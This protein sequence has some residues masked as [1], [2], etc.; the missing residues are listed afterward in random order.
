MKQSKKRLPRKRGG[1]IFKGDWGPSEKT[2]K[3]VMAKSHFSR[4][5][6]KSRRR[7]RRRQFAATHQLKLW[8]MAMEWL[9]KARVHWPQKSLSHL[10]SLLFSLAFCTSTP[11]LAPRVDVGGP[12]GIGMEVEKSEEEEK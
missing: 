1:G 11:T 12:L 8:L 5:W 2:L 3:S 10:F 6:L 4:Y 7:R 9:T